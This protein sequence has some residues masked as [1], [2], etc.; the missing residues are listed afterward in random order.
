M[1][2]RYLP[3]TA[4]NICNNNTKEAYQPAFVTG[5]MPLLLYY[6]FRGV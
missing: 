4:S 3:N 5:D 1:S 6:L 2:E